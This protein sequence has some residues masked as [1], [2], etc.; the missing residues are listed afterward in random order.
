MNK[1][2]SFRPV[3]RESLQDRSQVFSDGHG[4]NAR[5]IPLKSSLSCDTTPS[6]SLKL[7]KEASPR[8]GRFSE[9]HMTR[10]VQHARRH[11]P[12]GAKR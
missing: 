12:R 7:P 9:N 6:L 2:A 11:I 4:Y 10:K 3:G 8:R 5:T 1:L